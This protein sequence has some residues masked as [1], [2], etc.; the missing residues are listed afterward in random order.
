MRILIVNKPTLSMTFGFGSALFDG[1]G[2]ITH[3]SSLVPKNYKDWTLFQ[4]TGITPERNWGGYNAEY[5]LK[6]IEK[7]PKR[8]TMGLSKEENYFYSLIARPPLEKNALKL[9]GV[10]YIIIFTKSLFDDRVGYFDLKDST[11]VSKK[12]ENLDLRILPIQP[13]NMYYN[14]KSVGDVPL[15]EKDLYADESLIIGRISEPLSRAFIVYNMAD[16]KI[17]EF[18][19][20]INPIVDDNNNFIKTKSY[21]FPLSSAKI[22]KY[23]P[24][25]V[26]IRVDTKEESYLVLSDLYHPFWHARIDGK[27]TE[28][29]PAFYIFR[30]VKVPPGKHH[31]DFYCKVPY[32]T[33]TVLVSVLILFLSILAPLCWRLIYRKNRN[34]EGQ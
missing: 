16:E 15:P 8:K 9:L 14:Q 22:E 4:R 31:I 23:E 34:N 17:Y 18:M 7:L 29:I 5:S 13:E 25:N 10:K 28:I 33:V 27:E 11:F 26:S 3:Y 21:K 2:Q 1:V 6:T 20:E 32:F 19:N 12:I 24:E 30:A